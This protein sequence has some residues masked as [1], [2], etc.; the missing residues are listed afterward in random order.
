M[1]WPAACQVLA[2]P[3]SVLAA[4]FPRAMPLAPG[5]QDTL[6]CLRIL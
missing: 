2:R 1:P 6:L 3:G 5:V 4:A